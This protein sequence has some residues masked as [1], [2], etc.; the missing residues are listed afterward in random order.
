MRIM[1]DLQTGGDDKRV[2]GQGCGCT[3]DGWKDRRMEGQEASG[4]EAVE[5]DVWKSRLLL[6]PTA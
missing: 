2:E 1:S 5:A 3:V 4:M 6:P